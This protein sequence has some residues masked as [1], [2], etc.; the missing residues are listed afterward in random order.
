[1]RVERFRYPGT[2]A[3]RHA[4][5]M[6][7]GI[8]GAA[9]GGA[10]G[11]ALAAGALA[12]LELDFAGRSQ[13]LARLEPR[14]EGANAV[15][16]VPADGAS[17]APRTLVLVAHHDTAR[18]GLAWRHPWLGGVG[19]NRRIARL[20]G[21]PGGD[22]MDSLTTVPKLALLAAAA[23]CATGSRRLRAGAAATLAFGAALALDVARSPHVP[24]ASDN[25]TGVAAVLALTERFAREPLPGID[26]VALLT[27][28]EESG[29][30]GMAAWLRGAQ[31]DPATTLVLGLDTL[32]AGEPL[33]VSAE[34]SLRP[35]RYRERDL[36]WADRGADRAGLPRPQRVQLGGWTDPLL[37]VH[38]GLPAVS[39]LS[40]RDGWF[41]N[42][43]Q[44]T[45]TP[46]R[47]DWDSVDR[48]VQLAFGTAAAW[49]GAEG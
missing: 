5:Y 42:Y 37:A 44:P 7:A 26:V 10:G 19:T 13:W 28:C 14:G 4:A 17:G 41:T 34:G 32:G 18:T 24:G 46:D 6:A 23:G 30:G 36:A 15:G 20:R 2:Y 25:A 35:W 38:A 1:M 3:W 39:I 11:A 40:A 47:V 27:G 8:A 45:D 31:L 16:V 22:V 29:M 43:H 48:C 9:A 33:V 21:R 12:S 49:A